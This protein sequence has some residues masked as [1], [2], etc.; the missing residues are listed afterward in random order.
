MT[1]CPGPC[2]SA[3]RQ[4]I[5]AGDPEPPITPVPGEPAWCG[6]CSAAIR[7]RLTELDDAAA[8]YRAAADGYRPPDLERITGSDGSPSPSPVAD[9]LDELYSVL[10]DWEAAYLRRPSR[11]YRGQLAPALT[12]VVGVLLGH[13]DGILAHPAMAADFGEEI[14][15]WHRRLCAAAHL[16]AGRY[17]KPHPCPRCDL[18]TLTWAEGD[19]HVACQNCGRLM[20]LDEYEDYARWLLNGAPEGN[21]ARA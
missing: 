13:L 9:T 5:A 3:W 17:R 16:G 18:R 10:G 2:N 20:A 8:L 19:D 21:P 7:R 4:A 12:T 14:L 15:A 11:A 1:P 6:R